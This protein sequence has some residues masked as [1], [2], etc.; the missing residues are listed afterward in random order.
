MFQ[1]NWNQSMV[2]AYARANLAR[3][4]SHSSEDT[5]DYSFGADG[6]LDIVRGSDLKAG[7]EFQHLTEPRTSSGSPGGA[8]S[9]VQYLQ[10]SAYASGEHVINRIKL[11]M[12]G[13]WTDLNYLS[14]PAAGGGLINENDRDRH[15]YTMNGRVDYALSPDTALFVEAD[16]NWRDYRLPG[17]IG[18]PARDSKGY[19]LLAGANFDISALIRGEIGVGYL[20]QSFTDFAA[21]PTIGG[22]GLRGKVEWFPSELTTVTVSGAR[23]VEDA[24]IAGSGGYLSTNLGAQIDH[25]LLRNVIV[26]ANASYGNDA[27]K[28]IDRTDKRY[29]AGV[30]ATYLINSKVGLNAGYIYFKQNSSGALAGT[31]FVVNRLMVGLVLQY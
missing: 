28:G 11:S 18:A 4:A 25:E 5:T 6:R 30:N 27:Y 23:S 7:G 2:D 1:S 31:D 16:G 26:S 12:K 24:A 20:H 29:N 21:Y 13:D 8:L 14:A 3:N 19:Q 22:F 9:P 17:T 15:I 10:S